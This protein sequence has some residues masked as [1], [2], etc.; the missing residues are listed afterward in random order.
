MALKEHQPGCPFPGVIG[1]SVDESAPAW[2]LPAGAPAPSANGVVGASDDSGYGLLG[3]H[4]NPIG[5]LRMDRPAGTGL[6][7]GNMP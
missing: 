2:P 1:R 5:T 3:A 4:G 6:R 7:H